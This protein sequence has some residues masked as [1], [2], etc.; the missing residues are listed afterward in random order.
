MAR[1]TVKLRDIE[2]ASIKLFSLYGIGHVTIR[3]IAGEAGCAQGA[4]YRHYS[5]KDDLA[6]SLYAREVE[7]FGA[8]LKDALEGG[9]SYTKRLTKGVEAFYAQFDED[10]EMF[11]F[12]LLSQH[13]FPK[14]CELNPQTNPLDIIESFVGK[15]IEDGNFEIEDALFTASMLMGIVLQPATLRA[16]GRIKGKMRTKVKEVSDACLAILGIQEGLI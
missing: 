12:I 5:G 1:R 14:D 4:L 8:L 13:N 9:G 10:P 16:T 6:W 15:G 2:R 7:K 3:D 11:S